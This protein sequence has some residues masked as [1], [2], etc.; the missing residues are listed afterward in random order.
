[1]WCENCNRQFDTDE[2]NCPEC[3]NELIDYTPILDEDA[4]LSGINEVDD[5]LAGEESAEVEEIQID[6][7][8]NSQLLVTV[9]GEKEAKRIITLLTDNHIPAFEKLSEIQTLEELDGIEWDDEDF[10]DDDYDDDYYQEDVEEETLTPPETEEDS[11]VADE[12]L[13]DI[14]VPEVDFPSAMSLMLENDENKDATIIDDLD[15][16]VV[17]DEESDS[18]FI[19]EVYEEIEEILE[20]AEESIKEDSE[21]ESTEKQKGGFWNLFKK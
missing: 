8:A 7:E 6:I 10:E 2:K 11:L 14:F 17:E 12:T 16:V 21:T 1:M 4:D 15:E 13:Y 19:D 18:D 3:G 20:E 9:I 5:A